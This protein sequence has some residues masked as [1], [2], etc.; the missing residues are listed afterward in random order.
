MD[1]RKRSLK[2]KIILHENRA[3]APLLFW[4]PLY[5]GDSVMRLTLRTLLAYLDDTLEPTEIK[6][7]GQKVAESDAAQELIA[8]IKQVTRKRRLTTPP[9]TGP[10]AKF[11]PNLIAEYL[12]NELTGEQVAEIEKVCLESDVHL[13]EIAACHQILTLVLGEPAL[14]PPTARERMYGLVKGR[15]AIPFRKAAAKSNPNVAVRPEDDETAVLGLPVHK[16][17]AV[18]LKWA[19]PIAGLFLIVALGVAL[20]SVLPPSNPDKNAT[21][22]NS[23]KDKLASADK[24]PEAPDALKD[25]EKPADKDKATDKAIATDKESN[26]DKDKNNT[27]KERDPSQPPPP[28]TPAVARPAEASKER[29]DVALYEGS[30]RMGAPSILVSRP[31]DQETWT[32]VEPNK[33]LFSTDSLVSLP[34]YASE[35]RTAG[36]VRLLLWGTLPE[37]NATN[38]AGSFLYESAVTL[39]A[40]SPFDLEFTLERG[41]VYLSNHKD[42]PAQ[43]RVRFHKEIWDLVL[44]ERETEIVLEMNSHYLPGMNYND[45]EEPLI[46]VTL[47]VLKGKAGLKYD[48]YHELPNLK[49]PTGPALVTWNNKGAGTSGPHPVQQPIALLDKDPVVP[50]EI[51]KEVRPTLEEISNRLAGKKP[52]D[53]MLL[54][55]VN[56]GQA[57]WHRILCIYCLGAIDA[58]PALFDILATEDS[59]T[60]RERIAAIHTL[61]QWV[62]RGAE[63]TQVLYDA[64]KG[65]GLLTKK[66]YKP[67]EAEAIVI[68]LHNFT[69]ADRVRPETFQLLISYL[70]HNKM[71]IRELAYFHLVRMAQGA[72]GLPPYDPTWSAEMRERSANEWKTLVNKGELPPMPPMPPPVPPK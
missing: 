72:K 43:V 63:T 58:L 57:V 29:R 62:N 60:Q 24:A 10:G 49:G 30:P 36:G 61:R 47:Y 15:E 68:L 20:Y 52:I 56:S 65:T 32:R 31:R 34:G 59:K 51:L 27:D 11:D 48:S 14:V 40:A 39:H 46:D 16:R 28:V 69:A 35:L 55:G 21:S 13:A 1:G 12:D 22:N 4:T 41:R 53:V 67:A 8:R 64:K 3:P 66:N 33:P 17:Q 42:A 9:L 54:E 7:I 44:Q 2:N 45:G 6:Q 71:A 50:P 23:T 19:I 26:K 37:L 25:K 70:Q 38:P 18:W 5:C